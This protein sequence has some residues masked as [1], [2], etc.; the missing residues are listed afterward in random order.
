M[1]NEQNKPVIKNPDSDW[2]YFYLWE[3]IKQLIAQLPE[4]FHSTISVSGISTTEIYS[5]GAVLGLTIEEEVVRTLNN[6]KHIWNIDDN[7]S[8]YLFIRQAETFPDVLL[9]EI[10]GNNIIMGIELKSWYLLEKESEPS[11]RFTVTPSVCNKQDILVVVPWVLSNVLSGV[12]V[13]FEPYI[14]SAKYIAEYRNYWWRFIR[15][16]KSSTEIN[17]PVNATP[18]PTGREQ[19]SDHPTSDSGKNFGRIAR[20][21][22]MDSYVK[23]FD[24]L[25]L[26]GKDIEQWRKFFKD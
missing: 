11:F 13:I 14:E 6:L 20:V 16:A 18:Y 21:G 1:N 17:T 2:E 25:K 7:Y 4:N 26:L 9:K 12:P 10:K 19:I 3:K 24:K 15:K 23:Q 8:N 5:F 22:I